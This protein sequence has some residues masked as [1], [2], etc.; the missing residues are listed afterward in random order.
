M[1][2]A[3]SG[4]ISSIEQ[5]PATATTVLSGVSTSMKR[6][7]FNVFTSVPSNTSMRYSETWS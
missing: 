7:R 5:P 4:N 6:A 2:A 1:D 3:N